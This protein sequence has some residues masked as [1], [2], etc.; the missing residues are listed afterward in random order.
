MSTVG[1]IQSQVAKGLGQVR[2]AFWGIVAR[3][4]AKALQLTGFA[5]ETLQEV[6][7]VQQVGFASYIPKNA[8]VVVIPL[9][10]KTAKSIVIATSNGAVNVTVGNGEKCVYDQYGHTLWLKADG[11]H[12]GGGDLIIDEGNLKVNGKV[13][14]AQDIESAGQISDSGGSMQSMRETYN[15][16]EGHS[17]GG[18]PSNQM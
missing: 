10:G 17:S 9:H 12:V 13:I 18:T 4:G 14:A 11:T 1:A 3:G 15:S 16:H 8:K 6:E 7:L 2:Q 5:D